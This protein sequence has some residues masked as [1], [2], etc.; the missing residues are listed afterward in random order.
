MS[1]D[2][3]ICIFC[4]DE[5][6]DEA[7]KVTE[8][9]IGCPCK[10]MIHEHCWARWNIYECPICHKRIEREYYESEQDEPDEPEDQ[11]D[12][13]NLPPVQII[14]HRAHI[15]QPSV[16]YNILFVLSVYITI[17]TFAKLIL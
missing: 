12:D 17:Y 3:E 2:K 14:V 13:L 16:V 11:E 15:I 1:L 10:Y 4:F 7:P 6:N 9:I 8:N 5:F